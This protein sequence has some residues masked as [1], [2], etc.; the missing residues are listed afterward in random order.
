MAIETIFYNSI[1]F[2]IL[3]TF[4]LSIILTFKIS[5]RKYLKFFPLYHASSVLTELITDK[6][7]TS[8]TKP[9]AT[10]SSIAYNIFTVVEFLFFS[11]FIYT[12][13][14]TGRK[15]IIFSI[16][17]F[18]TIITLLGRKYNFQFPGHVSLLIQNIFLLVACIVYFNDLFTTFAVRDLSK[19]PAFW[20]IT[21]ILYYSVIT[22]PLQVYRL[23]YKTEL[24]DKISVYIITNSTAYILM[25]MLFIKAYTCRTVT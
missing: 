11:F 20:V 19:D 14:Q 1:R 2:V 25:Y 12:S 3:A 4:I 22:T 9:Y 21:G 7:F 8:S 6:Y 10:S 16:V 17:C 13:V 23:F 24:Y 15:V 5:S 18:L